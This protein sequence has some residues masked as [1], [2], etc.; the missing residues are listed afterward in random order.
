MTI[1]MPVY[2]AERFL[3]ESIKSVLDQT[4]KN[5]EIICV[6]DGCTDHSLEILQEYARKDLRITI[7]VESENHGA[8]MSRNIG[9]SMAHGE[10]IA[11]WDADDIY[12]SYAI[13]EMVRVA[14]KEQADFVCCYWEEFEGMPDRTS[15]INNKFNKLF[16][17]TYP[18]INT[19]KELHHIMQLVDNALGAKLVHKS[20]YK[21]NEIF[22]QDIPNAN[23]VYY[24][25]I[26]A[27]N[28]NKIVYV[29]KVLYHHR[30]NKD[31]HTLSTDRDTKRNYLLEAYDEIFKYVSH[32]KDRQFL[33]SSFYNDVLAN[34]AIY[35][36]SSVYN[37]LFDMLT[38]VYLE[39]WEMLKDGI[40]RKLSGI[41]RILYRVILD[42]NRNVNFQDIYMQAK[43]EFVKELSSKGCSI[44]GAGEMGRKLL[45]EIAKKGIVIQHVF[46]SA[47]D[48]WGE[49][50][51]GYVIENYNE[52][53]ADY[54]VV[55]TPQFYSEIVKTISGQAENIYNLEE[56]I[57]L[58]P[59]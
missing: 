8:A 29:D 33:L 57:W 41:N 44:W 20:L 59:Y 17:N 11:F 24:S 28:S 37:S 14:V 16:C 54:I 30:G 4:Y 36:G 56:Q 19:K 7:Q 21:K 40:E 45:E 25:K 49:K 3:G 23:D 22:F 38:S 15:H 2:N 53:Q 50:I 47:E 18:V 43:I 35:L 13:K 32:K 34:F 9:V 51:H 5:L 39:K 27:M 48:K 52:V 58:I 26:A 42:N 31:R 12:E 6:C 1:V 46:D 55:S 10:W